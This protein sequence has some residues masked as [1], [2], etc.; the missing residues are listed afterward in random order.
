[1]KIKKENKFEVNKNHYIEWGKSTWNN[2][3]DL[4][5]RNKILNKK[6][7]YNRISS[8]EISWNDFNNMIIQSIKKSKF[9]DIELKE[10]L[11]ELIKN[12]KND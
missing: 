9:S 2:G 11:F 10:I 3:A 4:S 12:M 5:I 6:G 7:K 8:S 1:M